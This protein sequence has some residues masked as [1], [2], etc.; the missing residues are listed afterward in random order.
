MGHIRRRTVRKGSQGDYPLI[1]RVQFRPTIHAFA[2]AEGEEK[3]C[4]ANALSDDERR[5]SF[6]EMG[7]GGDK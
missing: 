4:S 2:E 5:M 7:G 1:L 3:R 6:G